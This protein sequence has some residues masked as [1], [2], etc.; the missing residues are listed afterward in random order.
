MNDLEK[1]TIDTRVDLQGGAFEQSA[2]N[3]LNNPK[4][5]IT[6]FTSLYDLIKRREYESDSNTLSWNSFN[7]YITEITE[8]EK[9]MSSDSDLDGFTYL[10]VKLG[11]I[12]W[13]NLPAQMIILSEDL[14]RIEYLKKRDK[15]KDNMLA[16]VSHD[17][18]TPLNGIIGMLESVL[19]IISEKSIKKRSH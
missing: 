19:E 3:D 18:R 7:G 10:N 9:A 15:Y 16:T 14:H 2:T 6:Q 17:L 13:D 11:K 5:N 8:K 1:I 12:I 4:N